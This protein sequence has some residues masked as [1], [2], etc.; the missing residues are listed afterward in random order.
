MI[1]VFPSAPL[2]VMH[3]AAVSFPES[4]AIVVTNSLFHA[5]MAVPVVV[6]RILVA[7]V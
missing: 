2:H 1:A 3:G 6:V 4:M 7:V 5:R